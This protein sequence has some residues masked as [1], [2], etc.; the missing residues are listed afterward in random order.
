MI[1]D[2]TNFIESHVLTKNSYHN[3]EDYFNM[4]HLLIY[5][6]NTI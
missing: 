1:Y 3:F 5:L 4:L 6:T 2:S